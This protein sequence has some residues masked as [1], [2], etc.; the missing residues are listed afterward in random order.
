MLC[1]TFPAEEGACLLQRVRKTALPI[2]WDR[3]GFFDV[4]RR[5]DSLQRFGRLSAKE[6]TRPRR[7]PGAFFGPKHFFI[8][9]FFPEKG[10]GLDGRR[11]FMGRE[12][13]CEK[14]FIYFFPS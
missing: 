10:E 5:G 2:L 9:G 6:Y 4:P 8:A 13:K 11:P 12:K 7:V 1:E 3:T 14:I